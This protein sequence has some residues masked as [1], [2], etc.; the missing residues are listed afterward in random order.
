MDVML[1]HYFLV[2]KR[3]FILN[4]IE[5]NMNFNEYVES[6]KDKIPPKKWENQYSNCNGKGFI[7][8]CNNKSKCNKC[9][10]TGKVIYVD[11]HKWR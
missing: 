11:C 8:L 2:I 1:F 6:L 7:S 4:K 9:N 3:I 5:V 10:G